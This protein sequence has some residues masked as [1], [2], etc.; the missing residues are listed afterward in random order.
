LKST[1]DAAA[2]GRRTIS[3]CIWSLGADILHERLPGIS[4]TARIFA[5]IDV[6]REPIP[7]LPTVYFSMGGVLTSLHGEV[8]RNVRAIRKRCPD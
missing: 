3:S 7:V 6:T 1:R 4:E 5:G 8:M 2:A